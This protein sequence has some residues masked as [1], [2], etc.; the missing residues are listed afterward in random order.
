VEEV[1]VEKLLSG[2]VESV[3]EDSSLDSEIIVSGLSD[4][5]VYDSAPPEVT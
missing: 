5:F 1:L 3:G 4:D 2:V